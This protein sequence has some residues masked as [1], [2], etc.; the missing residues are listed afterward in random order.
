[1]LALGTNLELLIYLFHLFI[2]LFIY[3]NTNNWG[4]KVS[5]PYLEHMSNINKK[6]NYNTFYSS[7][8]FERWLVPQCMDRY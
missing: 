5:S 8:R 6:F 4:L 1:M 2:H 7:C 3:I